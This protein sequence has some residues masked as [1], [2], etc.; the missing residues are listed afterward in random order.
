MPELSIIHEAALQEYNA[1]LSPEEKRS[2]G[3]T[4]VNDVLHDV[5][6]LD[7]RQAMVSK[8]RRL[9][10]R[11]EPVIKFL[12]RYAM[13]VDTLVQFDPTPSALAWGCFRFI[14]EVANSYA[15]YFTKMVM[16][17][18]EIGDLLPLYERY[19]QMFA[20]SVAF[21]EALTN[22]YFDVVLFLCKARSVFKSNGVKIFVKSIWNQFEDEFGNVISALTRHTKILEAET[23]L[24]HRQ[25]VHIDR[26]RRVMEWLNPVDIENDFRREQK[27]KAKDTCSWIL[28]RPEYQTWKDPRKHESFLWI[29]GR[30]G[31]GKSVLSTA[32]IEQLQQQRETCKDC[33]VAYFFFTKN[34]E[35]R[36]SSL[37][38]I[39]SIVA[40][41]VGRMPSLPPSLF[42]L[43]EAA[44]KFGRPRISDSDE[45]IRILHQIVKNVETMYIVLDGLDECGDLD[46]TLDTI[47]GITRES[48]NVHILCISR[49][50]EALKRS[51]G[52][53]PS[54]TLGP[55]YTKDDID[56]FLR[57]E[58]KTLSDSLGYDLNTLIFE[59]LSQ[60]AKGNF[61]WAYL[62]I[63]NLKTA[64]SLF[65]LKAMM[66][67]VPKGLAEL[68]ESILEDL[69][70][71][72]E[73]TQKV[74]REMFTWICCSTFPLTWQE[75]QTALAIDPKDEELDPS[76]I[77][78][79]P[80]ILRLCRPLIEYSSKEDVFR[81]IHLSLCE[82]FLNPTSYMPNERQLSNFVRKFCRPKK[83]AHASVT[84]SCLT[85][86]NLPSIAESV[87][88]D[89]TSFPLVGYATRRWCVHLLE[90]QPGQEL[91]DKLIPF[92]SSSRRRQV[93][94]TRWLLM[95][96]RSYQLHRILH[97][98]RLIQ[99]WI[100]DHELPTDFNFDALED[101][102]Q[103]LLSL[104]TS[105]PGYLEVAATSSQI[106]VGYFEK[107]MVVRDLARG[108]TVTGRLNDAKRWLENTLS[109]QEE[110]HGTGS[111]ETVWI[112]NSL[113]LIY[114]QMRDFPLSAETQQHALDIQTEKLPPGHLDTVWTRNELGRVYR[115]LSRLEDA[116]TAHLQSL[117]ILE[118][119]LPKNDPYIIWTINC[120]A[121]A[122]R[123][124]RKLSEAL[125]L[126]E[127][128]L[129]SQSQNLG[130]Y[131]PHTL[132]TVSDI[133]RCLQ[134][135]GN[136]Q[137]AYEEQLKV[138]EGR[139][140]VLGVK[141]ADTCWS[142]NDVGMLLT[143]LGRKKEAKVYHEKALAGQREL[144]GD[145]DPMTLW[146]RR[147]L[148]SMDLGDSPRI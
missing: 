55:E 88:L 27:K 126:H 45:P 17:M 67:E 47:C 142:M 48:P 110:T 102:F 69:S 37:P 92:L 77:P 133:S 6:N 76:K 10:K 12:Q 141:H 86:L 33:E 115:H 41:L 22:M 137:G 23:T 85:Y 3:G 43:Y 73:A 118:A 14:I 120:L 38:L 40:Q 59:R 119:V 26:Q 146:T 96:M 20:D 36:G 90:S 62:M 138:L 49:E 75:I 105:P 122:Y 111:L 64:S 2:F 4:T 81:P 21:R 82:F 106:H 58:I 101:I 61:L 97:F 18:E 95:G 124:Q 44:T 74:M 72:T 25:T 98:Q 60:D 127:R 9:S 13:A 80:V 16:M 39:V 87:T 147:L 19:E 94:Q 131:H 46:K 139:E 103:I 52:S 42:A 79:K 114:D 91:Q 109:Q 107:M 125:A 84:V 100:K 5:Q 116:V 71:E 30:A 134:D 53:Y 83:E 112:L 113:G 35:R 11:I 65:E 66:D 32:I 145:E 148:E 144:F 57:D 68:Y 7:R 132:W 24:A 121:R 1:T 70:K 108:Y 104:D 8:T 54:I 128:A 89:K 143:K 129:E 135:Q 28:Q 136:L 140:K 29:N 123:H 34:D 117:K 50:T 93:W 56:H 99:T 15:K 130:F 63:C 78:F 31:S 51:L